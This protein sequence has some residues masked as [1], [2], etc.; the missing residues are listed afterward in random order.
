MLP[1]QVADAR[2]W[3][4]QQLHVAAQVKPMVRG[5]LVDVNGAPPDTWRYTASRAGRLAEPHFD[6]PSTDR[7]PRGKPFVPCRR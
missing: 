6:L 7:L 1:D 4:A 3:L 5:R 2:A